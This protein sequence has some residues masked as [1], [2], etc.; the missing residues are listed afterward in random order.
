MTYSELYNEFRT[1][2][3][4]DDPGAKNSLNLLIDAANFYFN[5]YNNEDTGLVAIIT[6]K[7]LWHE[8]GHVCDQ[9]TANF[10]VDRLGGYEMMESVYEFDGQDDV[11]TLKDFL[12]AQGLEHN[13]GIRYPY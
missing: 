7:C 5:V 3:E 9:S 4:S 11:G 1:I 12:L 13:P 8:E 6:P 2:C 10:L